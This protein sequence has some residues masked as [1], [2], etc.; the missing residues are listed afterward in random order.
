MTLKKHISL[1]CNKSNKI[2]DYKYKIPFSVLSSEPVVGVSL[3]SV[4]MRNLFYNVV[5]SNVPLKNNVFYFSLDAAPQQF[6]VKEGFYNI[7]TLLQLIIDGINAIISTRIQPV[8]T[9]DMTYSP[10]TGRVTFTLM[11]N[12]NAD[13]FELLGGSNPDS[14][15]VLIGNAEDILVD[16][17]NATPIV[18]DIIDLGGTDAI[19]LVINEVC[20]N[21]GYCN[22]NNPNGESLSLLSL[23]NF[24]GAPFGSLVC[25]QSSNVDADVILFEKPQNLSNLTIAV[26][27]LPGPNLDLGLSDLH[28]ELVIYTE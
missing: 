15:N 27:S 3:K 24:C 16:A 19:N 13:I 23:I 7:T 22:G 1:V 11:E 9:L 4:V 5:S 28:I 17:V 18:F 14:L 20:K 8:Q 21:N 12:G 26:Q 6:E 10:I 2:D 25:Y